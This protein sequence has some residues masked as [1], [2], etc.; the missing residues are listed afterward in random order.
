[1]RLLAEAVVSVAP[2]ASIGRH[3]SRD[4]DLFAADDIVYYDSLGFRI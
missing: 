4:P 2:P 3:R 1:M